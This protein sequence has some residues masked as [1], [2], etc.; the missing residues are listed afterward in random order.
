MIIRILRLILPTWIFLSVLFPVCLLPAKLGIIPYFS[1]Y[2]ILS[3]FLLRD[4]PDSIGYVWVIRIFIIIGVFTPIWLWLTNNINKCWKR[5]ILF[6]VLLS[7][8]QMLVVLL[9]DYT[10]CWAIKDWSLYIFGYSSVFVLGLSV[11]KDTQKDNVVLLILLLFSFIGCLFYQDNGFRINEYKYP[12]QFL[13][14]LWGS[15]ISVALWTTKKYWSKYLKNTFMVWM[16]QNTIWI[17][18]WHIPFLKPA[19]MLL[20]DSHWTIRYIFVFCMAVLTFGIQ[21]KIVKFVKFKFPNKEL[22]FLK[23]LIG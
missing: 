2:E 21:Y 13:F 15:L 19:I 7:V 17:Y 3:T 1:K 8:Q 14:V 10:S 9:H 6:F 11:K 22:C 5:W 12:P 18:L 20:S 16:G 23:Y 4:Q